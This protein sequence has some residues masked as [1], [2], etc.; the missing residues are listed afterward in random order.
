MTNGQ[1]IL[2]TSLLDLLYELRGLQMPLILG[3]GF[4]LYLKQIHLQET[5]SSATLI[6]GNLWPAPRATEDLDILLTTEVVVDADRMRPISMALEQLGYKVIPGAEYMQF[7][8]PLGNG[9][10]VKIDLLTGP[11]GPFAN[12]PRIKVDDRRVRPRE[13]V[14]LH[15]HRTDEAVGFQE[16]TLVIAV[17]GILSNGQ[18]FE[19]VVHIP[20]AFTLLLMKLFA[21]RDR[22]IDADKD[23][24]RHHALDLYRI[25][26]IMTENEYQKT[27]Q[28]IEQHQNKPVVVEAKR[29]VKDY[30]RSGES[31][32]SLRL[33]EHQL[34]N[35]NMALAEFLA[36]M[37]DLFRITV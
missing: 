15:A 26:A 14:H 4:G 27:E 31:L 12:D 37:K 33:R 35:D 28:R 7:A 19:G 24:G 9:M 30:F 3:G 13:S 8:K 16:D 18:D 5:L 2:K 20:Q 11:L 17:C 10:T 34:W 29:I 6:P 1:S 22:C 32:G 25:V 23:M 21:F 36:A